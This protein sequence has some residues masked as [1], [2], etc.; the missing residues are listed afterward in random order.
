MENVFAHDFAEGMAY[1]RFFFRV[2]VPSIVV[3]H[4]DDFPFFVGAVDGPAE[5]VQLL[6]SFD[7]N[8]R[9]AV[10]AAVGPGE[11]NVGMGY[12]QRVQELHH[13]QGVFALFIEEKV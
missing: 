8:M 7:K 5:N 6:E 9:N 2:F 3:F 10:D 11:F 4:V 1:G 12:L 13:R